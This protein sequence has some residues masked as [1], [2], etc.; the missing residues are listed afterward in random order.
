MAFEQTTKLRPSEAV[1]A[2]SLELQID[3]ALFRGME[4][5]Q[6]LISCQI[7][8]GTAPSVIESVADNYRANGWNVYHESDPGHRSVLIFEDR[9]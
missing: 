4:K 3:I 5:K 9:G 6:S 1:Q 2:D 7:P 8:E